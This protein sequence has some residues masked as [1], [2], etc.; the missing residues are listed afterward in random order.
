MFGRYKCIIQLFVL[1]GQIRPWK[2]IELSNCCFNRKGFEVWGTEISKTFQT[3]L[4]LSCLS[5]FSLSLFSQR[6]NLGKAWWLAT[7]F[8]ISGDQTEM[9]IPYRPKNYINAHKTPLNVCLNNEGYMEYSKEVRVEYF[10]N[11]RKYVFYLEME[12]HVGLWNCLDMEFV[13]SYN[14]FVFGKKK[15]HYFIENNFLNQ[16]PPES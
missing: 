13:V 11:K 2:D 4:L 5:P 3:L 1:R 10:W 7:P 16:Q 9:E 6:L 14:C 12:F 8:R 15:I